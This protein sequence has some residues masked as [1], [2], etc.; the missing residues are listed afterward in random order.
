MLL[1]GMIGVA[2]LWDISEAWL[3]WQDV[4]SKEAALH[5]VQ[6]RDRELLKEAAHEGIDLSEAALQILPKEIAFANQLIEKRSFSWT[7]FLTELERAIPQRIAV[8]SIRLD[9]ANATIML[10]G[11]ARALEDITTL[12][13]TFQ[14]HPQF[15]EPVL[16]QHRDLGNGL[17]EFD[18]SLRYRNR[19][20]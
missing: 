3:V 18:L 12:T 9:P 20:P 14:D 19:N 2:M 11:S 6:D 8:N 4:Q 16:G 5:Q 7:R 10:T 17:V 13:V 15:K 1:A